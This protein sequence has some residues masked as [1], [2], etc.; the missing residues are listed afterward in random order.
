MSS[1][2]LSHNRKKVKIANK[3]IPFICCSVSEVKAAGS[4]Q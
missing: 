2:I 4:E 3:E 1:E